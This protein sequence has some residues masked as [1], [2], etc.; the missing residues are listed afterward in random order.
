[1]LNSKTIAIMNIIMFIITIIAYFLIKNIFPTLNTQ[2]IF[3]CGFYAMILFNF[4][5]FF[6]LEIK[7]KIKEDN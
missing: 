2:K 4:F 3:I 6:I 7:E 5:L 1:M